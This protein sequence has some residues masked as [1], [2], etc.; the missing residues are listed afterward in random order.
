MKR[1]LVRVFTVLVSLATICQSGAQGT[2]DASFGTG[3]GA[4]DAVQ[5]LAVQPDGKIMVVGNFDDINGTTN[6]LG[7]ARLNTNGTVD[8]GFHPGK[9]VDFAIYAVA[10]QPDG[11]IIIGGGFT[12]YQGASRNGLARIN[13]DG[14]LDSTYSP[15]SGV[16]DLITSIAMQPDRKAV[17]AGYFTTYNG[18]ARSG[19]AR[20]NTNGI[21]DTTFNPRAGVDYAVDSVVVQ[22]DGKI[23]L[24]GGFT[25]YNGASRRGVARLNASGLVDT[26]FVPYGTSVDNLVRVVAAQPDGKVLIGGDFTSFNG[27][28]RSGIARLNVNGT[29]D[30]SF[31]PGTGANGSVYSLAVQPNGK[32]LVAGSFSLFGG[33]P[34]TNIA[35]LLPNGALD[36][37]FSTGADAAVVAVALQPDGKAVIGG[38]FRSINAA[39]NVRLARL[40]L[41]DTAP[42]PDISAFSISGGSPTLTWTSAASSIYRIDFTPSLSPASWT[43]FVPNIIATNST[44]SFADTAPAAPQRFYRVASLPY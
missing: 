2:L 34:H 41:S 39:S 7:I 28:S 26:A 14:S 40:L 8:K 25:T 30:T 37:N 9:S 27:V 12:M 17:I 6:S 15:G 23:L 16:N 42:A 4:Q 1:K 32:I 31:N 35:R 43:A 36:V 3:R 18:T 20:I 5:A 10:I 33:V 19:I 29:L 22:T 11:K 13:P 21:L 44:A 38:Q 24:G